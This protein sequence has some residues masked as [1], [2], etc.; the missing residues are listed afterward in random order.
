MAKNTDA[1]DTSSKKRG[2]K[3]AQERTAFRQRARDLSRKRKLAYLL[4]LEVRR[5]VEDLELHEW[6]LLEIWTSMRVREPLLSVLR[7]RYHQVKPDDLLMMPVE[8]IDLLDR[9]Y[10]VVDEFW[11]YLR[12][13][14]DMPTAMSVNYKR[15]VGR[16]K[17]IADPL[18]QLLDECHRYSSPF[19]E[20]L[21]AAQPAP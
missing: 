21:P 4:G 3:R 8:C 1:Q 10:R 17:R 15:Y 16:L 12:T 6:L 18:V 2:G 5:I 7:T 20:L 13:T 14:E 9:F 11:L 19:P